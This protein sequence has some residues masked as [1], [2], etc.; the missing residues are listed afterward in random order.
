VRR[1]VW[2]LAVGLMCALPCRTLADSHRLPDSEQYSSPCGVNVRD[3][4]A[5]SHIHQQCMTGV[6][7]Q[8]SWNGMK[9][10]P[11]HGNPLRVRFTDATVFETDSGEGVLDGLVGGDYVCV[12]YLPHPRAVTGLVVVFAPESIP[13]RSRK[14]LRLLK[15]GLFLAR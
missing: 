1:F 13:C 6:A 12:A 3:D 9:V 7:I 2:L 14:H 8:V 11:A 15:S 5:A 10:R 4:D